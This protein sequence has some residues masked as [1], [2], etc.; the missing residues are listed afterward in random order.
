MNETHLQ[1]LAESPNYVEYIKWN[2]WDGK[3]PEVMGDSNLLLDITDKTASE[4]AD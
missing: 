2:K 4:E 3:L 1:P